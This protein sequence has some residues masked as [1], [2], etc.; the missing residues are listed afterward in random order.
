MSVSF[1]SRKTN[2][3]QSEARIRLCTLA[4][5][6]EDRVERV[7]PSPDFPSVVWSIFSEVE[8]GCPQSFS[9]RFFCHDMYPIAKRRQP[10]WSQRPALQIWGW[11][12]FKNFEKKYASLFAFIVFIF[13]FLVL[14]EYLASLI[15]STCFNFAVEIETNGRKSRYS[16]SCL[17]PP[18]VVSFPPVVTRFWGPKSKQLAVKT[19]V[20]I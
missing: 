15:S 10:A 4:P 16:S 7:K 12:F 2:L 17:N 18:P 14:E 3:D 11:L 19:I 13:T 5:S 1:L 6:S 8:M 9:K 20:S